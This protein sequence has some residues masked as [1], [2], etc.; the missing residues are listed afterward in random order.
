MS[1]MFLAPSG[2]G[3]A[4]PVARKEWV[5][6]KDRDAA[7]GQSLARGRALGMLVCRSVLVGLVTPLHP[8][9]W[10]ICFPTE[11]SW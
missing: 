11:P 7:V 5:K 10:L 9:R 6:M 8:E 4:G 3:Q 2:S 1:K